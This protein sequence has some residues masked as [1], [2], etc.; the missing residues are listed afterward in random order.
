MSGRTSSDYTYS[1]TEASVSSG[2]TDSQIDITFPTLSV[3]AFVFNFR[4]E[5]LWAGSVQVFSN[6]GSIMV[7]SCPHVTPIVPVLNP[8]ASTDLVLPSNTYAIDDQ[9]TVGYFE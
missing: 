6:W 2:L 5:S 4:L 7:V 9:F 3:E 8:S 1:S